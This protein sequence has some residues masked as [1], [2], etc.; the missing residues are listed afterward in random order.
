MPGRL[1]S[2]FNAPSNPKAVLA[3][4]SLQCRGQ[5]GARHHALAGVAPFHL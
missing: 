2:V 3:P 4:R 5:A 1:V